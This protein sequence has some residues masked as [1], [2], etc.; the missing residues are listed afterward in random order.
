VTIICGSHSAGKS[1]RRPATEK[2]YIINGASVNAWDSLIQAIT[3]NTST[4][5][6]TLRQSIGKRPDYNGFNIE[7]CA[8][9]AVPGG[10]HNLHLG[11]RTPLVGNLAPMITIPNAQDLRRGIPSPYLEYWW[12]DMGGRGVR[13][14]LFHRGTL[15]VLAGPGVTAPKKG[16]KFQLRGFTDNTHTPTGFIYNLGDGPHWEC[17]LPS[18]DGNSLVVISDAA[19]GAAT[20]EVRVV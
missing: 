4:V 17:L 2:M 5:A 9:Q 8:L 20:C 16:S 18:V 10:G 11:F 13:D 14:M 12:L 15:Y 19:S 6:T 7:G 1:G 3:P